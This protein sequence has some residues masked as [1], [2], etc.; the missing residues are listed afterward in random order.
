MS[1]EAVF[2]LEDVTVSYD[3]KPAVVRGDDGHPAQ[4]DHGLHRALGLRQVDADPLA[5]TG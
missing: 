1:R 5:S 2:E 4:R 3:G